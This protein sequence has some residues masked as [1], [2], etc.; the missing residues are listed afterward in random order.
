[1]IRLGGVLGFDCLQ[2]W[3]FSWRLV[4]MTMNAN[5]TLHL[6]VSPAVE[7]GKPQFSLLDDEAALLFLL[8][9]TIS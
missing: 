5:K 2:P 3:I 1:V 6:S 4:K 7:D 8:A 9:V